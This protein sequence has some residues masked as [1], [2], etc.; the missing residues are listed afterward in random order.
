V[1]YYLNFRAT[2][3]APSQLRDD[4]SVFK[5]LGMPPAPNA[6]FLKG[7]SNEKFAA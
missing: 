7:G 5:N 3:N 2:I 6:I 4:I 1:I